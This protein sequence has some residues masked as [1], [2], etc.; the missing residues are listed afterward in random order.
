VSRP[1]G[2][3]RRRARGGPF[4]VLGLVVA[5]ALLGAEL[6][7]SPAAGLE[8][9]FGLRWLYALRGTLPAPQDIVI[10]AMDAASAQ[11][12]GVPEQPE[13]WPRRLHARLVSGLAANGARA[14]GFDL[15]FA[16]PRD[17][18][19][20]AAFADAMRRAGNVVL[21]DTLVRDFVRGA[22]GGVVAAADRRVPPL[23]LFAAAASA[24]APFVLPKAPD[25]LALRRHRAPAGTRAGASTLRF[26]PCLSFA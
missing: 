4:G 10:V 23:P 8:R 24:T 22:D 15:L 5:S 2:S 19:D 18:D 20:D 25:R 14:I 3:S 7:L 11:A 26:S 1:E 21:A 12:L 13:G 17:P 9:G 6:W 16:Q